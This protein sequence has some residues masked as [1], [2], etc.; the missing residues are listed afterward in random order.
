MNTRLLAATAFIALSLPAAAHEITFGD[1]LKFYDIGA[2][3]E[4]A[5]NVQD[6]KAYLERIAQE[7]LPAGSDLK[8]DVQNVDLAGDRRLRGGGQWIRIMN[9]RADWPIITVHYKYEQPGQPVLE[10]NEAISDPLYLDRGRPISDDPLRYE[11]R[12]LLDWFG[13][14]LVRREPAPQPKQKKKK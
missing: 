10:G 6:L 8:L 3:D 4:V 12:M 11:K 1:P 7:K 9:G 14:R 2:P 5:K 13:D